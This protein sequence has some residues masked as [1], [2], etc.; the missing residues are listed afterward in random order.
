MGSI[1]CCKW[2]VKLLV[3]KPNSEYLSFCHEM[4]TKLREFETRRFKVLN[5][6]RFNDFLIS[7]NFKLWRLVENVH[8]IVIWHNFWRMEKLSEVNSGLSKRQ[9]G[10]INHF[11]YQI[12]SL[13]K[14]KSIIFRRF[15]PR[16]RVLFNQAKTREGLIPYRM[17][18]V[19][20]LF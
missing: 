11:F 6:V 1:A 12:F 8:W 10:M 9:K 14:R 13:G 15:Q 2:E 19:K 7:K 4:C 3:K 5:G 20:F 17:Q 18:C 16:Y